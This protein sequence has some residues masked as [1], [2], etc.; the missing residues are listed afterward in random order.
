M[1]IRD[2]PV[3]E[4][5]REKLLAL[6]SMAISDAELL[7]IFLRTGV[8][9]RSAVDL[10]RD[11]LQQFGGLRQLLDADKDEFCSHH[12]LGVAKYV[13]MQASLEMTRRHMMEKLVNGDVLGSPDDTRQYLLLRMRDYKQE[14]F[15]C[16]FLDSRNRVIKFD[17]L[18]FGTI[19]GAS[20]HPREVVKSGLAHNAAAVILVHNHPSGETR[21][22]DA[23]KS[24][25]QRLKDALSL[26]DIRVLDHIIVGD[27]ETFSFAERG[28]L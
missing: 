28:L 15:A 20:V 16:L 27:G 17:E 24:I 18:F 22:S 9:G 5:P 2:W 7:A 11:L 3:S 8:K 26:V 21:P 1:A 12:G 4:Q 6:G 19:N 10:A 14:V 23:D 25:T 13:Q